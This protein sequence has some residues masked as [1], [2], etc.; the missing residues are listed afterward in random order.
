LWPNHW[1]HVAQ[2][3]E[4]AYEPNHERAFHR[5]GNRMVAQAL[6]VEVFAVEESPMTPTFSQTIREWR[7][8]QWIENHM[9][10][11]DIDVVFTPEI[12]CADE[13]QPIYEALLGE[14][15]KVEHQQT[16]WHGTGRCYPHCVRCNLD[17]ILGKEK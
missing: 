3:E 17:R 1:F 2:Q 16:I 9:A 6:L 4:A 13:A 10:K 15:E 12:A 14:V 5:K 11:L 8:P 7:E